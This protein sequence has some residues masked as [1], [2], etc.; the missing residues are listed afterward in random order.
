M[1]GSLCHPTSYL[2]STCHTRFYLM[3]TGTSTT[4]KMRQLGCLNSH[5]HR[6]QSHSQMCSSSIMDITSSSVLSR[7]NQAISLTSGDLLL[8]SDQ[9][10]D[11][12][13]KIA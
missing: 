6:H 13:H 5:N 2:M 12:G 8:A 7:D 3:L 9:T 10:Q 1:A 4:D 11:K